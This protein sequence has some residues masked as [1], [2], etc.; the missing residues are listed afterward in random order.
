[1][2]HGQFLPQIKSD[3]N[4]KQ[5]PVLMLTTTDNPREIDRCYE[6]GCNVYM[7]KPVDPSVFIEAIQRLDLLIAV[8]SMRTAPVKPP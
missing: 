3:A 4:A 8:V 2:S 1:M 5:I 6:L 7:T